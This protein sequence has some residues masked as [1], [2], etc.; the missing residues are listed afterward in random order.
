M[1]QWSAK[2]HARS[3]DTLSCIDVQPLNFTSKR[4]ELFYNFKISHRGSI[5]RAPNAITWCCGLEIT[6]EKHGEVDP[7]NV[8]ALWNK[9]A[10]KGN[11]LW[12]GKA[13]SVNN[14]P[15]KSFP[16]RP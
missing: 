8:V 7:G 5:R 6:W 16:R 13:Q 14:T 10:A 4:D 1:L 3:H 11:A 9:S 2:V 15:V 12:A